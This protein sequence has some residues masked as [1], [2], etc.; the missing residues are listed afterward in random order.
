GDLGDGTPSV[1]EAIDELGATPDPTPASL[2]ADEWPRSVSGSPET[3]ASVLTQLA[4]R[5]GVDE[6][7]VQ[8]TAPDHDDALASHALLAEA[9]GLDSQ[10]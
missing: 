6:V 3:I 9:V 4:D 7:M 10:N 2:D 8:H 1:E 5:I